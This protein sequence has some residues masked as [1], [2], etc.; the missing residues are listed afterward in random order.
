LNTSLC[1]LIIFITYFQLTYA[2]QAQIDQKTDQAAIPQIIK[3][4]IYLKGIY[5]TQEGFLA[6]NPAIKDPFIFE[7]KVPESKK[8]TTYRLYLA[9]DS[10]SRKK[11]LK[12]KVWGFSDGYGVYIYN[13]KYNSYHQIKSFGK[14]FYYTDEGVVL[15]PTYL[16]LPIGVPMVRIYTGSYNVAYKLQYVIDWRKRRTLTLN[17]QVMTYILSDNKFL[18]NSYKKDQGRDKKYFQYI[19]EYNKIFRESF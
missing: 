7:L 16:A 12:T 10:L 18:L 19:Q 6:N 13:K 14:Y 5:T 8:N 2:Q 4:T 9:K 3:D 17:D 15:H 11:K 1:F